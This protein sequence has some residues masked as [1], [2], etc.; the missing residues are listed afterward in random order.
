MMT[1]Q[2][3]LLGILLG[4]ACDWVWPWTIGAGQVLVYHHAR[5]MWFNLTPG[6]VLDLATRQP[7]T[8]TAATP[9]WH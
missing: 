2:P 3:C 8:K 9:S 5:W 6:D 7:S 1:A 4:L